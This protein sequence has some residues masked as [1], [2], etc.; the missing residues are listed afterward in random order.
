MSHEIIAILPGI[1]D[2]PPLPEGLIAVAGRE[3]R[4]ILA[5]AIGWQRLLGGGAKQAAIR[6]HARLEA[7]LPGGPVLPFRIGVACS[8]DEAALVLEIDAALISRLGREIGDR[9]HYQLTLA[10]DEAR[11]LDRFRDSPELASLFA[12]AAVT[13]EALRDAV[14]ALA[15]RL[16]DTA[17]GILEPA[18]CEPL[19]QPR[20][21][22]D[23]LHLVFLLAPG[24]EKSLETALETID[25]LWP[26][27]FRLRLIGPSAPISHGLLDLDRADS[28]ALHAAARRLDLP[29][30]TIDAACIAQASRGALRHSGLPA[31][32]ADQIRQAARLLDQVCRAN[33][34]GWRQGTALPLLRHL[35]DNASAAQSEGKAA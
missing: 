12:G 26:E 14:A 7:L 25:A 4:A 9:R 30:D 1:S 24:E 31:N 19:E 18:I 16:R 21:P 17:L 33:A 6:H 32:E 15:K 35:R 22:G 20:S 3:A 2:G 27:G 11:V 5:P 10:W 28:A 29:L 23:L 13:A 34:L 8:R